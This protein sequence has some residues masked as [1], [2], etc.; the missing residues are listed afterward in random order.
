MF[1]AVTVFAIN[2][3]GLCA[4]FKGIT[5]NNKEMTAVDI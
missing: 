4:A 2:K 5:G 1:E 3:S